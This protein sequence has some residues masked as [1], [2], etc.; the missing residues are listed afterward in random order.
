[1]HKL[2]MMLINLERYKAGFRRKTVQIGEHRIAYSEG[3]KGEPVL[4]LHGFGASA[5]NWNR[6]ASQLTKHYHVIAADLPGGAQSAR[7]EAESYAYP[8]Q[9]ER[10]RHFVSELGL[11]R[12]H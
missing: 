10:L 1:M 6:F 4:L 11:K 7:L 5:D 8:Q 9:I 12:F 3:G 2:A